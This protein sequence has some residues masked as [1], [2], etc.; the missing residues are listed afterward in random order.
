MMDKIQHLYSACGRFPVNVLTIKT[1]TK[2]LPQAQEPLLLLQ[3]RVFREFPL[4]VQDM[5]ISWDAGV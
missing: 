3:V 2:T 4:F 1:M 5:G